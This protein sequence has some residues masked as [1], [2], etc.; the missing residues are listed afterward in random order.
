MESWDTFLTTIKEIGQLTRDLKAEDIIKND[1]VAGAN[2][3]DQEK[4]KA[5]AMGYTLT[6]EYEAIPVPEGAGA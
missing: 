3:F 2:E 1:F 5:D 4:V 6:P